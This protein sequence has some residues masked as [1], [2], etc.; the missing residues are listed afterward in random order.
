M[1][2]VIALLLFNAAT[3]HRGP[4]L[5]ETLSLNNLDPTAY[6][7]FHR[8]TPK[9]SQMD[10][11]RDHNA[12]LMAHT[13]QIDAKVNGQITLFGIRSEILAQT[14][15]HPDPKSHNDPK[16]H[17]ISPQS[18]S[19][20]QPETQSSSHFVSLEQLL[21][22]AIH[23][24]LR[25]A[26]QHVDS[27]IRSSTGNYYFSE[28]GIIKHKDKIVGALAIF[29]EDSARQKLYSDLR[30][31]TVAATGLGILTSA[32]ISIYIFY[33]FSHAITVLTRRLQQKNTNIN[34]P[35][36]ELMLG[37]APKAPEDSEVANLAAVLTKLAANITNK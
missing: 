19:A 17:H 16:K 13:D 22:A 1:V 29:I 11:R 20:I 33:R 35:P 3:L 14:S 32:Q 8:L 27:Y 37:Q 4:A 23:K 7:I 36:P 26:H 31:Q 10:T 2:L 9:L 34:L 24:T 25:T 12:Q 15:L 21:S 18:F 5:I 6:H 28:T 30:V